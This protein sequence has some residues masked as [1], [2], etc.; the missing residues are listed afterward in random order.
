MNVFRSRTRKRVLVIGPF[1][2]PHFQVLISSLSD[3]GLRILFIPSDSPSVKDLSFTEY[4]EGSSV[5][6]SPFIFRVISFFPYSYRILDKMFGFKWRS[7]I[8]GYYIRY[9][10]P[11][12]IHVN[13]IQRAGY[14][15]ARVKNIRKITE[16]KTVLTSSWG[17]DLVLFS[18][19]EEHRSDMQN[20]LEITD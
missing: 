15:L 11:K 8:I 18:Q 13:E 17:S 5:K 2:S 6:S 9:F 4:S 1:S 14:A 19:I 12:L 10:K 7:K 20:I 16:N 3:F